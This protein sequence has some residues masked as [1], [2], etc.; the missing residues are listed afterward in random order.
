M[1]PAVALTETIYWVGQNDR[2]TDLFEALWPLP[3]GISYN[4]Y[5][6][7]DEKVAL[8]DTVKDIVFQGHLHQ[9]KTVLP[10]GR[11]IDYLIINHVEPDHSSSIKPLREVFP[12]MQIVGTKKTAEYLRLLYGITE[13]VKKVQD[14]EE[15]DLG[16]RKLKFLV[17]P[18]VHWPETM[19]TYD[20]DQKILF[21]GDAFGGFGSL[22]NGIFDDQVDLQYFE[23][24]ILRYF[25][26]IIGRY[27]AMVIKAIDKL[28][29]LEV[30]AIAP[31]HGLIWRSG[32]KTIIDRHI[33][34]SRHEAT[35]GAVLAY[36]SMYGNTQRM[37]EAIARGLA[38]E[39]LEEIRVHD[40]SRSHLSYILQ[41]CWRFKA[42][43]LGCPTY[44]TGLFPP[45]ANLVRQLEEK[46]LTN[47]TLGLFGSYGWAGGAV[48]ELKQF[49]RRSAFELIEP[50]VEAR[51]A[52]SEDDL[53]NCYL[54]GRNVAKSL[55]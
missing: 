45:M 14:G 34:W 1:K 39:G 29:D 32:P 8:I 44:D 35:K 31:A 46:K 17:T 20:Q 19:M 42:L 16:S 9:V 30:K 38:D 3:Q 43:I 15:L 11:S 50:V 36:G 37:M 52:P 21:S 13:N 47:R 23:N 51:F 12:S 2:Q 10:K 18:M 4:S 22:D 33:A 41:D 28:K 24:E 6:I 26:N 49:Q 27:S 40:T 5:L 54:L 7:M 53:E 25:S 55:S 48:T